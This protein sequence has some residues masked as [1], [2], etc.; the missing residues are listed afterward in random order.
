MIHLWTALPKELSH[1]RCNSLDGG[2]LNV[3]LGR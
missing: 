1:S 2:V 3:E